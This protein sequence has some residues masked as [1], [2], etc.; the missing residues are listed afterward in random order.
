MVDLGRAYWAGDGVA[1]D[2]EKGRIWLER[3]A[4]KDSV[5]AQ[6]L[7]GAA[8][9]SGTKLPKNRELAAKYLL[10]VAQSYQFLERKI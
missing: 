5:A 6:M 10:K 9:L 4:E 8:Y 3:A 1:A 7:L 2:V